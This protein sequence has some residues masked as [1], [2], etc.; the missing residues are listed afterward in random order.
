[1]KSTVGD[2]PKSTLP[3]A[4]PSIGQASSNSRSA[5]SNSASWS[6]TSNPTRTS[7]SATN[8]S[9][10][11]SRNKLIILGFYAI[12][13][14]CGVLFSIPIIGFSFLYQPIIIA[15]A[16]ASLLN[17]YVSHGI[18]KFN[19]QWFAPLFREEPIFVLLFL[20]FL[21]PMP[22]ATLL[23]A[24][25]M[26]RAALEISHSFTLLE[27]MFPA[28]SNIPKIN[29][30]VQYLIQNK[31]RMLELQS[32]AELMIGF[33]AIIKGSLMGIIVYWQFL[34]L[35]YI[36]SSYMQASFR[37]LDDKIRVIVLTRVPPVISTYYD[38]ATTYLHSFVDVN[39][40]QQGGGFGSSCT[41]M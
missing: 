14:V 7:G 19:A 15:M 31:N 41:I 29:L 22:P 9:A 32:Q 30:A 28:I 12:A 26:I 13:L 17:I 1:M 10:M 20:T 40:Q 38:K 33:F 39:Q 3:K 24:P 21:L 25:L 8:S 34:R 23:I 36:Q 6:S 16:G 4:N 5:P 37:S 35:R 18:P 11:F 2:E 27:N